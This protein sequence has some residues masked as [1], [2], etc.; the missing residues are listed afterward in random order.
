MQPAT[1]KRGRGSSAVRALGCA[2]LL[3]ARPALFIAVLVFGWL[4]SGWPET[5]REV[6]RPLSVPEADAAAPAGQWWSLSYPFSEKITVTAGTAA[7]ASGY[8]VSVTFNHA[9]LVTAGK[10]L[11]SGNDVRVVYWNGSAWV[12]LDRLLDEASSWNNASTKVWFKTQAAIG[13]SASDDNYYLYYGNG[14]AGAPPANGMN[15]YLFYDDFSGTTI[16]TSKWTVTRGTT[17]VSGGILTV[18]PASSIW[19]QPTYAFG[20]DTRWEASIQLGGDGAESSFNFLA[21]R[22]LDTN[23]WTGNW[24]ILW[25]DATSHNAENSKASTLTDSGGFTDTTP[26]LFHTYVMNREGTT[27]VRYFQDATQRA[28]LTTNVPT[29]SLRP[30]A[31]ADA[32]TGATMWQKYD[33]WKVRQY[34]TPEPT[35]AIAAEEGVGPAYQA[36]GTIQFNTSTTLSVP[37]PAH[38]IND[39]GLLIIE[40]QNQAVTLGTNAANWTPVTNSPQGTGTTSTGTKLTVFWSRATSTSM[41]NV[42]LTGT[43]MDHQIAQILTFRGVTT[44]G[45]PWDVTAGDVTP[46]T[47]TAVSIPG[48]TTT[49]QDTLVVAIV[50]NGSD[51]TAAQIPGSFT[52]SDL[53]SVTKRQDNQTTASGGGGFAVA[54]GSKAL[55]GAYG[56]TSA[57]LCFPSLQGRMS[58][59]LRPPFTKLQLLMPGETAAPGTASGVT[60]TPT[61]QTAGTAFTVTVNAVDANWYLVNTVTDTVGITSTDTNATMPGNAALVAGTKTFS[62]TL[63]TAGTKTLTATDITD[64]TKTADT[65]PSITVN[66]GTF[67]KLQLLVPGETAAPGTSS[68]G[69]GKTGSPSARAAGSSFA[70]TVNAVDATWNKVTT[71][72]AD[73]VRITS[74]GTNATL[75]AD[76]ALSSG[77]IQFSVTLNTVQ[78]PTVTASDITD[79]FKT[80]NTSPSITVTAG[81]FAK[82]QLLAPGETAAPGTS[83]SGPGKTGSPNAQ[84]AGGTAFTVT[85]N[86]VDAAWNVVTSAPTD[87][88]GIT[89]TDLGAMP[90]NQALASGTQTFSVTLRTAGSQTLT[91]SDI[92]T[93]ARTPNSSV[94]PVTAGTFSKLQLLVPGETA[95]ADR[96]SVV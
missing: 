6:L 24:I 75:P 55:A 4:F 30:Y 95:A 27:G 94:I 33:W 23:P 58:I 67:T 7:T 93:P 19:A 53:S 22:D 8:S 35:S 65:S 20:T 56:P 83:S 17:S 81:A 86:A 76:A 38:A 79:T 71:A 85:V 82:L 37:W 59:A 28:L 60:G 39:I 34:V 29:V 46:S 16:D 12:E 26:T 15:V 52:N 25:S 73:I 51:L 48:A 57:T 64:G 62:V 11:A 40:T 89:S 1:L 72:P 2:I 77:T 50:A 78:T 74:S 70:V 13:A 21:A 91:A 3:S 88:V 63:T 5:W 14:S 69:S 10:S 96:K 49:V 66:V 90:G 42:G 31:F 68:S 47:T 44:S 61:A 80:A 9:S 92:T 87:T 45:N 41:G 54:T 43:G 84:P 36:A 18:N 32:G